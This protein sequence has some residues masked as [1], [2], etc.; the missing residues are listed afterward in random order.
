[1]AHA[2]EMEYVEPTGVAAPKL[3]MWLFLSGEVVLFG[4]VIMTIVLFR[5]SFPEWAKE[6]THTHTI[7]GSVNTINLLT[8]SL[9]VALAYKMS[10]TGRHDLS[11]FC[12]LGTIT[13]GIVFLALK[14]TV[15][16][17]TEVSHGYTIHQGP[18]W[19][20]YY[21]ATGLHAVHVLLGLIAFAVILVL[22]MSNNWR[23]RYSLEATALYWHFVDIVW[24]FLWPLF[25]LS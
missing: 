21:G 17:P 23:P 19:Q 24:L 15:E 11:K 6:S 16:W 3:G 5:V 8:S 12:L 7:I 14:W 18:F 10:A 25:Y 20:L 1:M 4:G 22:Y 9:L 2:P 13:L